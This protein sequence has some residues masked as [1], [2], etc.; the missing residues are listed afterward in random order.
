MEKQ[1]ELV[2]KIKTLL[3]EY[4]YELEQYNSSGSQFAISAY[5]IVKDYNCNG[6]AKPARINDKD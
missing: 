4:S 2:T 3:E 6:S 5:E 1:F